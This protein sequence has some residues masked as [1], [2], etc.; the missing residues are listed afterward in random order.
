MNIYMGSVEGQ[1]LV[2]NVPHILWFMS[3]FYRNDRVKLHL[4]NFPLDTFGRIRKF[5]FETYPTWTYI[6]LD[7][8]A[9]LVYD[10]R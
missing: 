3:M 1:H 5:I 9:G 6:M 8:D 4:N 7:D 2:G 10:I